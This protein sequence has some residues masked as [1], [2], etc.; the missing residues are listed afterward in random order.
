MPNWCSNKLQVFGSN[1]DDLDRFR[2]KANG[3]IQSYNE[4]SRVGTSLDDGAWPVHDDIR[5][6]ALVENP[7]EPGG[8]VDFSFHALYPVPADFRRFPYDCTKAKEVGEKVGEKRPYGGYTWESNHWGVKWGGCQTELESSGEGFL[9]YSF[10]T[11]WGPPME[12]LEKIAKDWPTLGFELTYDEP[13]HGFRG[14]IV[15]DKGKCVMED[16]NEY[17]Y[18]INGEEV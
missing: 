3:P 11:P 14:T 9:T 4:F 5:L 6:K 16:F 2:E 12:F 13:G 18:D 17:E 7:P 1:Q 10:E 15:W 8:D